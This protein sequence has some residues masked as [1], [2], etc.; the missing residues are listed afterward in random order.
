M[1]SYHPCGTPIGTACAYQVGLPMLLLALLTQIDRGSARL[2]CGFV[3]GVEL[4]QLNIRRYDGL[5]EEEE[6]EVSQRHREPIWLA[7]YL[8]AGGFIEEDGLQALDLRQHLGS[9][10]HAA[11]PR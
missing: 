5:K 7:T 8:F 2:C 3:F 1:D 11:C 9:C 10:T 4:L 6:I